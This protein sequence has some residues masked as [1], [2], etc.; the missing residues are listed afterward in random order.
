VF[1]SDLK[2]AFFIKQ[3]WLLACAL[4][5]VSP[6]TPAQT[7]T[8]DSDMKSMYCIRIKI[9]Y[10]NNLQPLVHHFESSM[11]N[12]LQVKELRRELDTLNSDISR[13]QSY[14]T[15]RTHIVGAVKFAQSVMPAANRGDADIA[16]QK[17]C[18]EGCGSL[19]RPDGT[20]D[21]NKIE[22]CQSACD[23]KLSAVIERL[24]SCAKI[25]WLP[26]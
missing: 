21:F 22:S 23:K 7:H 15:A 9:D 2:I 11:P 24:R 14:L 10:R 20:P 12:T 5:S 25:T 8:T 26:F 17:R 19:S 13:L 6:F 1:V 3:R 16:S 4:L 18:T